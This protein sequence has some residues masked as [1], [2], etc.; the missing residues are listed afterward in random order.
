MIILKIRII[1][2]IIWSNYTIST[3]LFSILSSRHK[4]FWLHFSTGMRTLTLDSFFI[5]WIFTTVVIPCP[6]KS[7]FLWTWYFFNSPKTYTFFSWFSNWWRI[8]RYWFCSSLCR[9]RVFRWI[10][11]SLISLIIWIKTM[12]SHIFIFILIP[13]LL[14]VSHITI[15]TLAPSLRIFTISYINFFMTTWF[16]N[17]FKIPL[18]WLFIYSPVIV[19]FIVICITINVLLSFIVSILLSSRLPIIIIMVVIFTR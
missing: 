14:G 9:F 13:S 16:F 10:V 1:T 19:I 4:V 5:L 6:T 8:H 12:A 17:V 7:T 11:W 18:S 3:I 2:Q 15:M